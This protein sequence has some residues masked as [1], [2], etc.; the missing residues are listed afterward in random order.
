MRRQNPFFALIC[1]SIITIFSACFRKFERPKWDT[2]L[3]TPIAKTKLSINNLLKDSLVEKQIDSS[4]KIV[5]RQSLDSVTVDT[6][7]TLNGQEYIQS[8]LLKDFELNSSSVYYKLSLGQ[9]AKNAGP[10]LSFLIPLSNGQRITI[11]N[12]GY[13][14]LKAGP[15]TLNADKIFTAADVLTGRLEIVIKN[16]LSFPITNVNYNLR[17][18]KKGDIL[19]SSTIPSLLPGATTIEN[20]DLAGKSIEGFLDF[21]VTSMDIPGTAPD[22]VLIDT[23][24]GLD[25]TITARNLKVSYAQAIFP[26]QNVVD[27]TIFTKLTNLGDVKLKRASSKSGFVDVIVE[28]TAPDTIF[29][30]YA[31]WDA[32]IG[33]D[34]FVVKAK[35][36]PAPVGG[37]SKQTFTYRLDDF[38]L[39]LSGENGDS[40]NF[41]RS[42]LLAS[43][44]ST[45]RLVEINGNDSIRIK[46]KVYDVKASYA[47]GYFGKADYKVGPGTIPISTFKNLKSGQLDF[48]DIKMKLKV[49]NGT[50][51]P[52]YLVIDD[53]SAQN[54][55]T[56]TT[57]KLNVLND[58]DKI[59]IG[60]ADEIPFK[61]K[62]T[63]LEI[64]NNNSN[65]KD[66][67]NVFP[68]SISYS[69]TITTNPSGNDGTYSN[70]L[71]SISKVVANLDIEIPLS[72]IASDLALSDTIDFI[73][74]TIKTPEN[75]K[76]GIFSLIVE[77]GFPLEL[78]MKLY[79]L[80]ANGSIYDELVSTQSV[81][82]AITDNAGRVTEKKY[83]KLDYVFDE[84]RFKN[85]FKAKKLLI[86]ADFSTPT[87]NKFYKLYSDYTIDIKM[88]GDFKYT[89][90]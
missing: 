55:N 45:G 75:I 28:S 19:G 49:I 2:D 61:S 64:N 87:N 76:S 3:L 12:P 71:S 34:T 14:G 6:L 47:R 1:I 16:Q 58:L 10:P 37:T 52:C 54:T 7:V 17:N 13:L 42:R 44:D 8:I 30:N 67:I 26:R 85:I 68:N 66:F 63:N 89:L 23:S 5:Y 51:I 80:D 70:F 77:N 27:D 18:T 46:I 25:L 20:I 4:Y 82:P 29:F 86:F 74:S 35:T 79:L 39:N 38:N 24:K 62:E 83:N 69:G 81:L 90:D 78:N 48:E 60:A 40:V 22:R 84:T 11:A 32:K 50:G 88:V 56:S 59:T 53:I 15:V 9:V 43:F 72:F 36:L 33:N 57:K 21:S 65:L 41:F 73:T 31:I